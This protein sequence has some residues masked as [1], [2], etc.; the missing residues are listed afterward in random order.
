MRFKYFMRVLLIIPDGADYCL[1]FAGLLFLSWLF[2]QLFFSAV[3]MW[4]NTPAP[5]IAITIKRE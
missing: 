5:L 3:G 1:F 4:G 2:L